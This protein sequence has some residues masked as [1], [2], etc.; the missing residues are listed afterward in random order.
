LIAEKCKN[1]VIK[2]KRVTLSWEI[3]QSETL[4]SISD[5]GDGFDVKGYL[6]KLKTQ[7]RSSLHGRGLRIVTSFSFKLKYNL[8][9]N[10]VIL[11]VK[12]GAAAEHEVP[13]G[14]SKEQIIYVKKGSTVLKEG[15]AGNFLYFISSGTYEVLHN[16]QPVGHLSQEDI[17]M[18][19]MS[20]LLNQRRSATIKATSDG[21]LIL[22]TQ[23]TLVNV[24]KEY[25]HYGMFLSKLLAKRL[26]RSNEM[27]AK[28]LSESYK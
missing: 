18:G 19:E 12:H 27:T 26:V 28:S 21:K 8:K 6:E 13:I 16:D 14:F 3:K 4:F 9:G 5:E 7:D 17:F 1:P 23:K 25:P 24:I 11:T 15:D 22:L 20:F 10:L 2:A